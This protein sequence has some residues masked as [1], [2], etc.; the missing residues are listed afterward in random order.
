M[1]DQFLKN[2]TGLKFKQSSK[3]TYCPLLS[4]FLL[5]KPLIKLFTNAEQLMDKNQSLLLPL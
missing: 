5:L 4:N 3:E 1:M 2:Q